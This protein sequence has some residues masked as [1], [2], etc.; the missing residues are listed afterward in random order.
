MEGKKKNLL[1]RK[2]LIQINLIVANFKLK[3]TKYFGIIN[4]LIK[5]VYPF[6]PHDISAYHITI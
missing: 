4:L 3:I 1:Q 2:N 5:I 6:I